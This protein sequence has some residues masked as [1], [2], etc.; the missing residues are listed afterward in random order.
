MARRS[1]QQSILKVLADHNWHGFEEIYESVKHDVPNDLADAEYKKRHQ[2]LQPNHIDKGK[3]RLVILA[4]ISYKYRNQ[5]EGRGAS[6]QQSFRK[7]T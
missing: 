2:T 5:I 6:G 4:L 7:P 1:Y 3:R